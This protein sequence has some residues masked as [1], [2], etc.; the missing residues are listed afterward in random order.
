MRSTTKNRLLS[1]EVWCC[2]PQYFVPSKDA[3]YQ[4]SFRHLDWSVRFQFKRHS[5]LTSGCQWIY[6]ENSNP[7][8][9]S[10]ELNVFK[11]GLL[12]A[13]VVKIS[14]RGLRTLNHCIHF[15]L[16][17]VICIMIKYETWKNYELRL[18]ITI[19]WMILYRWLI[20]LTSDCM[21]LIN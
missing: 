5:L 1:R 13:D 2:W 12:N 4:K 11:S 10:M 17:L 14:N 21:M 6:Y 3:Y 16:Q 18:L 19:W 8:I 7:Q 20:Y 9:F 15:F